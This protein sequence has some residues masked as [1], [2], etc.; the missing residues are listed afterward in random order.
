MK[1][2]LL[3]ICLLLLPL[4]CFALERVDVSCDKT[5]DIYD[6]R[7]S[8]NIDY[9]ISGI[10]FHFSLPSS[11][12]LVSYELDSKWEGTADDFWVSVY[13]EKDVTGETPIL[14]LKIES[15]KKLKNTDIEI[16][17]L[18]IIDSKYKEHKVNIN[19]DKKEVNSKQFDIMKLLIITICVIIILSII[20]IIKKLKGDSK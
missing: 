10:D 13:S 17:D 1:Y 18:L 3:I 6:C 4:K 8:A 12:K 16:K 7:L 5:N 2:K 9:A 19:K 14:T 11:A 20:V 15:T